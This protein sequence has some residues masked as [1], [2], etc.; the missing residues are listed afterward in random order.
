MIKIMK[1]SMNP[2]F[3]I[4]ELVENTEKIAI[5]MRSKYNNINPV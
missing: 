5:T 2:I 1:Q 4:I 3:E